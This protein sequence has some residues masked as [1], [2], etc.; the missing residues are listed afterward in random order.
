MGAQL[1]AFWLLEIMHTISG[2]STSSFKGH[3]SWHRGKRGLFSN[4]T[5]IDIVVNETTIC[6]FTKKA[7]KN[8]F[9]LKMEKDSWLLQLTNCCLLPVSLIGKSTVD[10]HS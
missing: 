8:L 2:V 5:K 10:L 9:S 6:L 1:T 7:H 4:Q 3:S